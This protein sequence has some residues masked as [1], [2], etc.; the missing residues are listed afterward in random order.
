VVSL[1]D[2]LRMSRCLKIRDSTHFTVF[3]TLTIVM[4]SLMIGIDADQGAHCER[5][6]L[7]NL[8]RDPED[9]QETW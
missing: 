8:K 6:R 7:R 3:V 5:Y 9:I 1:I 2:H 4:V